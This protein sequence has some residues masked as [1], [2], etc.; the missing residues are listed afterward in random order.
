MRPEDP[1]APVPVPARYDADLAWLDRLLEREILRLR[2]HYELSLDELRGLYISDRQVDELLRQHV[3]DGPESPGP[4]EYLSAEAARLRALRRSDTPLAHLARR[5]GLT[6]VETDLLLLALALELS[7][8][9]ETLYAYLNNDITRKHA[10]VDLALRVLDRGAE[11]EQVRLE[12]RPGGSLFTRGLLDWIDAGSE[13]RSLRAQGFTLTPPA[14]QFLLGLPPEDP[15]LPLSVRVVPAV[16]VE[17]EYDMLAPAASQLVEVF[18][19]RHPVAPGLV[20]CS[21]D[22]APERL[23]AVRLYAA[24]HNHAI[25]TLPLSA[26]VSDPAGWPVFCTRLCLLAS[27]AQAVVVL[28]DESDGF[29]RE[30]QALAQYTRIVRELTASGMSLFLAVP[31]EAPWAVVAGE[32]PFV[33]LALP[34]PSAE[35]RAVAWRSALAKLGLSA[36]EAL[37]EEIGERFVLSYPRILAAPDFD[38]SADIVQCSE[39]G[40]SRTIKRLE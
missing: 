20:V 6:V 34:E 35:E 10:T 36:G 39:E 9:Y 37:T 1:A 3:S 32:L 26:A 18:A 4:V 30:P 12:L 17:A 24:R 29:P 19:A 13:R 23:A 7:L 33:E 38:S 11:A 25:V 5:F 16:G 27:L 2:A 8:K 31:R 15:R 14:A 21:G 40:K 22:S 28:F